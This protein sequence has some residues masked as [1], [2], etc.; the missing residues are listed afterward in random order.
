MTTTIFTPTYNRA[1]SLPQL[2]ESLCRQTSLDFEWVIVDDC[3]SDNTKSLVTGWI[4]EKK[5]S[6]TYFLQ[7]QNG[8]K[9]R[10]INKGVELAQGELFFIVD[11]DDFLTDDAI[12]S[13]QTEWDILENKKRYAG[14]CFRKMTKNF[15]VLGDDFP[16]YRCSGTSID[17]AY[18][19]ECVADK[20]EVFKTA[21]LQKY[22]FP[23][24]KGENFC[25]EAV[26]WFKIAMHRN[27]LLLCVNK[28][29]YVCEYL[30]DGLT[31]NYDK[32]MSRNPHYTLLWELTLLRIPYEW[33]WPGIKYRIRGVLSLIYRIYFKRFFERD[34]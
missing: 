25:Q 29:I 5:I 18:K 21:V 6:I 12:E 30:P 14:I 11:S 28:G 9:H 8:G 16:A 2:Y 13:I 24:I 33:K 4:E 7:P 17:I 19:W 1:Y 15:D 20:A 3:S 23:D 34:S 26:I 22:P 10:A 31:A 32:V 27:A